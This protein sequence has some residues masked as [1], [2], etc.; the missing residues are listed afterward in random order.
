MKILLKKNGKRRIYR[1]GNMQTYQKTFQEDIQEQ[2]LSKFICNFKRFQKKKRTRFHSEVIHRDLM[3]KAIIQGMSKSSLVK[4]IFHKTKQTISRN[5]YRAY[6]E[7][8]TG[9][10]VDELQQD[11]IS[12]LDEYNK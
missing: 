4:W 7:M 1:G 10:S 9:K 2:N 5:I 8:L 6:F 11:A 3:N 12:I